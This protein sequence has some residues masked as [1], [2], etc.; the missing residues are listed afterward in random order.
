MVAPDLF[1]KIGF[2]DE[3][4]ETYN[5]YK[6]AFGNRCEQLAKAYMR[7]GKDFNQS[8]T[9]MRKIAPQVNVY[10]ADMIFILECTGYTYE[11]YKLRNI[12]L[13]VFYDS[14][15]DITYKV[16]ECK[17]YKGVYGIFVTGWFKG[18]LELSR[19]G[20]G[21]LQYDLWEHREDTVMI[22]GFKVEKGFPT[23]A[24]HIPSSGPLTHQAV[25]DS[26]KK[27]Y[28]FFSDRRVDGI[29]LIECFSWFFFPDYRKIFK[30]CAKNIYS[31][32]KNFEF[33]DTYYHDKFFDCWRVFNVDLE[34]CVIDDLPENTR[35][36]RGFKKY[37]KENDKFG[38]ARGCVLFDGENIL[39]RK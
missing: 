11:E 12:D 30:E 4:V 2:T 17:T 39:T 1:Q 18:F 32:M 8:C 35:L 26:F 14:M 36:Q 27:A 34:N 23:L 3:M 20:L 22:G 38:G 15:K 21:R 33:Y 10:T 28:D 9:E 16:H 25:V 29:L 6:S 19:F 13:E 5:K 31:F 7:D 37:L 24:C